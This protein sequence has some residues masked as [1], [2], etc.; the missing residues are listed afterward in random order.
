MRT[1]SRRRWS[2]STL[3][4]CL[5]A[6]RSSRLIAAEKSEACWSKSSRTGIWGVWVSVMRAAYPAIGPSLWS[7]AMAD[8]WAN[9]GIGLD[10]DPAA[11]A[12]CAQASSARCARRSRRGSCGRGRGCR[13]HAPWR[14][15]SASPETPSPTPTA[16]WSP[17]GGSRRGRARAR[18]LPS[19]PRR[20]RRRRQP[21]AAAARVALRPAPGAARPGP[22][23]ARGLARRRPPGARRGALRRARLRRSARPR[24]SCARPWPDT[25]RASAACASRRERIVVCSGFVQAL[26][27][28]LPGA[29][30]AR[31]AHARRRGLRAPA[32]PRRRRRRPGCAS[33]PLA[34]DGGGRGRRRALERRRRPADAG[35]PVPARR[36]ARAGA[37]QARGR[38]GDRHRR[39]DHR[40]RLRR[41]VPLRP[42]GRGGDAGARARA[43][44]LRRHREQEP[45]ARPAAG[46]AGRPGADL[47]EPV[48]AGQ[49]PGRR[50]DRRARPAHAGRAHPLAAPTTGTSAA[51]R[52]VY[53]RRRE[54]LVAALRRRV[55]EAHVA[56]VAAGLQALVGLPEG[57]AE[58]AVVAAAAERGLAVEGLSGF[59]VAPGRASPGPGRRLRDAARARVHDRAGPALRRPRR[60][61][62]NQVY[63]AGASRGC[64]PRGRRRRSLGPSDSLSQFK[65]L[66]HDKHDPDD[67]PRDRHRR[68]AGAHV[69]GRPGAAAHVHE[70]LGP[71]H[72]RRSALAR[73][74]RPHRRP[75]ARSP[76]C[77]SAPDRVD[78]IGTDQ[79]PTR[80]RDEGR[81]ADDRRRLRLGSTP[82]SAPA[83]R[84]PSCWS[85]PRRSSPAD[86]G[87]SRSPPR[88]HASHRRAGSPPS[89]PGGALRS[90]TRRAAPRPL[91]PRT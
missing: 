36:P 23:P 33:T 84:S 45:R 48:V 53:Q 43:R 11:P 81:R 76:R 29:A 13:R 74:R 85:P 61:Q 22:V 14:S 82:R 7:N 2:K 38:V 65:E 19:T 64:R 27:A 41:R 62:R 68:D 35:A 86:A 80:A 8:T 3:S 16:S 20:R 5:V 25:S 79:Q 63:T 75:R 32:P 71:D 18:A 66:D 69:L 30:R 39:P 47:V 49:A 83:R 34:V 78:K 28:A 88:R 67:P 90:T 44:R 24:R 72:C 42:P 15:T 21:A 10:R 4:S 12:G 50:P 56:G 26:G 37:A 9:L 89:P 54:R 58:A 73:S 55:P 87:A 57:Q 46:L 77:R 52:L 59:A 1:S 60:R 51:R 6:A 31:R 70:Q 40:G 17:R 91:R